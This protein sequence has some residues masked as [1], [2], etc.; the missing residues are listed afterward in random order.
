MFKHEFLPFQELPTDET[1]GERHYI[2]PDGTSVPSVTTVISRLSK[3]AIAE[4]RDRV[5]AEEADRI[6]F[7]AA[8][9]GTQIHE[10]CEQYLRN[11]PD[12]KKDILPIHV[13]TFNRIKPFFDT[14]MGT[15][16]GL[17]LPLYSKKLCTA[18][19]TDCIA[20]YRDK[21]SIID[22]K[23]SRKPKREEWIQGYFV[24]ATVYALMAELLYKLDIPQIVIIIAVDHE[25]PQIFRKDKT[26]YLSRVKELFPCQ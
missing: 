21:L 20:E 12:Y 23:T 25:D 4:W 7:Q 17:E 1:S 9:R 16:Y 13:D 24:Q 14:Y 10:I 3:D 8:A 2:L 26:K 6:S 18:G 19:R 22:F 5:G 11:N 15:I